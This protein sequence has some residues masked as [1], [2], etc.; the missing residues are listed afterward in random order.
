MPEITSLT[1][2]ASIGG[3]VQIIRYEYTETYNVSESRT[4]SGEWTDEEADAFYDEK[5]A[6]I[7]GRVEQKAQ[8]EVDRLE[9]MRAKMNG[10]ED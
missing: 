6:E 1:V 8:D 3:S 9:A 7:Y 10:V 4:Y 5:Y 2:G